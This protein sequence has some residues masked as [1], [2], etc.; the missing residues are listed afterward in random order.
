MDNHFTPDS[1]EAAPWYKLRNLTDE[2]MHSPGIIFA[3]TESPVRQWQFRNLMLSQLEIPK[4][5]RSC[6]LQP[7][8]WLVHAKYLASQSWL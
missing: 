4:G 3:H 5:G 8:D 2:P 6:H 1:A 7:L